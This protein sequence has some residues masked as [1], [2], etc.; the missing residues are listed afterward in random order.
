M[1]EQPGYGPLFRAAM[2]AAPLLHS[3]APIA[4]GSTESA[5]A[6]SAAVMAWSAGQA[7]SVGGELRFT[8]AVVDASAVELNAPSER[9]SVCRRGDRTDNHL[10]AWQ[11]LPSASIFDYWSPEAHV[12]RIVCGAHCR[13]DE[14]T[15]Q[16][17]LS[18]VSVCWSGAGLIDSV[19]FESVKAS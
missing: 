17:G 11:S 12:Q 8:T 3:G 10:L 6:V 15:G 4:A 16:L 14:D 7:V 2:G 13:Q 9:G 5:V 18:R 19:S 1:T